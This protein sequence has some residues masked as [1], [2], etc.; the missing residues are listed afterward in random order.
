M[1]KETTPPP[2]LDQA[3]DST[4]TTTQHPPPSLPNSPLAKR[5][6]RT[7]ESSDMTNP[8]TP[9]PAS[10][11]APQLLVKL[12]VPS[13]K[14]PTRGSAFAAGYDVYSAKETVIP[15]KGKG[16]VDTGI[17]IAV[18]E[19]TC[20]FYLILYPILFR[21]NIPCTSR[22][23]SHS[24]TPSIEVNIQ[25]LCQL[26]CL[27]CSILLIQYLLYIFLLEISLFYAFHIR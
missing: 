1:T 22:I 2:Q 12:L 20:M 19:G 23:A 18:S 15:A 5:P 11:A 6:K 9:A 8:D 27:R 26:L 10:P 21:F 25:I 4:T 16:L 14:A 13:A 24:I 3:S 17:S 7:I